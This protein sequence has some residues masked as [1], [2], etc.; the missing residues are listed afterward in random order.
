MGNLVYTQEITRSDDFERGA[1]NSEEA[2]ITF[3]YK[4]D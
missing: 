2:H 1:R 4:N 3:R